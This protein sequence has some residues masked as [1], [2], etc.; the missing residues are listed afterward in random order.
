MISVLKALL[1][2]KPTIL[3]ST[4]SEHH[5]HVVYKGIWVLEDPALVRSIFESH[6]TCTFM[7]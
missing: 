4:I 7:E 6:I 3:H 1:S 2:K 5:P